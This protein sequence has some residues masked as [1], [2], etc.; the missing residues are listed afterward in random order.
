[1]DQKWGKLSLLFAKYCAGDAHAT[2]ELFE[3]ISECLTGFFYVRTRSRSEAE[4]LAQAALLKI[5]YARDR[6]DPGLSLKTWIFTIA[7]RVLIDHWRTRHDEEV[8][9][10]E[11]EE[12]RG[13]QGYEDF[14]DASADPS[15][16]TELSRD[17][18]QALN[19]LKPD[20]RMIVYLY[21]VEGFSMAEIAQTMKLTEAAVKVRAHRSYEKMRKVLVALCLVGFWALATR[22]WS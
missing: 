20:D 10:S 3:E 21:A 18:N 19:V 12:E 13:A 22:S 2:R 8:P 16:K 4:D 15:L 5:H 9:L 11:D 7:G 17:L 6:F 1:M 14:Q